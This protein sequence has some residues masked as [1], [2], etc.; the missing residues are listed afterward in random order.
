MLIC[1]AM[2]TNSTVGNFVKSAL[3]VGT[4]A[5]GGEAKLAP[6]Q[7]KEPA[8]PKAYEFR[9]IPSKILGTEALPPILQK[10]TSGLLAQANGEIPNI[11]DLALPVVSSGKTLTDKKALALTEKLFG[12]MD[13]KKPILI[14]FT[15][16]LCEPCKYVKEAS[17][18]VMEDPEFASTR[19]KYNIVQINEENDNNTFSFSY[20]DKD[21]KKITRVI[22]E[23]PELDK[24]FQKRFKPL[25]T[26]MATVQ[27]G[28][29][30]MTPTMGFIYKDGLN[31]GIKSYNVDPL[32]TPAKP[33][34]P[35]EFGRE[36]ARRFIKDM[37]AKN[38]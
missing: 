37:Q 13:P 3:L 28:R 24:D 1:I 19:E 21:G 5:L 32:L 14:S 17:R 18:L 15:A 9:T 16:R 22:D 31:T 35:L 25:F 12:N 23:A 8:L 26:E 6:A 33:D 30:A 20:V 27:D 34:T 7:E 29:P 38:K 36:I 4:L 10:Q 2:K 11:K